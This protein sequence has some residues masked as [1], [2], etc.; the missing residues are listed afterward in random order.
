MNDRITRPVVAPVIVAA[1]LAGV[2]ASLG[3]CRAE[4]PAQSDTSRMARDT[5]A[6]PAA[7][8]VESKDSSGRPT[9]LLFSMASDS[10]SDVGA[11]IAVVRH[12]YASINSHDYAA[13]Y[14]DWGET[15]P[16]GHLPLAAFKLGFSKTD[17]V[18]VTVGAPGRIDAAAGSRYIEIPVTV[19]ATQ[20][21]GEVQR[22]DGTYTL[23]RAVVD[24]AT[25]AQRR[26]HLY[27]AKLTRLK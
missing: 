24:G 11:A 15:G 2:L 5:P 22:Y 7:G 8:I 12:Y 21:D 4:H 6:A 19:S 16:P 9:G 26:W 1:L 17:S 3:A 25:P 23:R 14:A 18:S 10:A 20:Q 27:T 13:A